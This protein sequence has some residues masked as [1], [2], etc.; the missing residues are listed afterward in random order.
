MSTKF[1]ELET[2]ETYIKN[3]LASNESAR[4]NSQ[5]RIKNLIENRFESLYNE[6]KQEIVANESS[7]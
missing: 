5:K 1:I 6:L 3:N 7:V 4:L 2:L